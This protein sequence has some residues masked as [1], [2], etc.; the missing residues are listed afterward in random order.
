MTASH[1]AIV[2]DDPDMRALLGHC[3][4]TSGYR[5]TGLADA[6]GIE[7]VVRSGDVDLFIIDIGLPGTDGLTVTQ[8]IRQH[9]DVS[10]IIVSG[11]S[12]LTDRVVGL[13]LGADDYI[14]KP[15]ESREVQ[16]R[17]KSVLRRHPGATRPVRP[18]TEHNHLYEFGEWVLDPTSHS[19][20]DT[21]G[22]PVNLTSGEY[23]LL[24]ALVTRANRVLTRDQL[25][26]AC[27][28]NNS[29]AFDR[30]IDVCMGRL[31]KKLH[32][33]PRAPQL[34]RTIRNFGYMFAARVT[35]R[36]SDGGSGLVGAMAGFC[37]S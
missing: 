16:A 7:E 2:E 25:M 4:T 9:S 3:L 37:A 6:G 30:T 5:V 8:R 36:R 21:Q 29:P 32:D 20:Q 33:D 18:D 14:T 34:I 15:F 1:I 27:Y 35:R 24:E 23:K 12:D 11:R 22:H 28:G 19:L 17:V 26:D 10:I 13:E 31:R